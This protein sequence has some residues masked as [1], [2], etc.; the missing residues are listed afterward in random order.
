M[1]TMRRNLCRSLLT[2]ALVLSMVLMLSFSVC[3][4]GGSYLQHN[5]VSDGGV[6]ADHLV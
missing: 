2:L 6:S 4:A 1:I 5:L 3:A